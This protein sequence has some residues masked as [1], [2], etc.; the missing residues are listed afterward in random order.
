MDKT[1][2][3]SR[4]KA[5]LGNLLAPFVQLSSDEFPFLVPVPT[6]GDNVAATARKLSDV[7]AIIRSGR[8]LVYTDNMTAQPAK[9][10]N[11]AEAYAKGCMLPDELAMYE[12]WKACVIRLPPFDWAKNVLPVDRQAQVIFSQRA[13]AMDFI[14][15]HQGATPENAAYFMFFRLDLL[16]LVK[17]VTKLL[18]AKAHLENHDLLCRLSIAEIAE[19]KA[20]QLINGVVEENVALESEPRRDFVQ[21]IRESQGVLKERLY[22]LETK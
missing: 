16:P 22:L 14:W 9:A 8:S 1:S 11:D 20:L 6:A 15:H 7:A 18:S 17:A 2:P 4:N 21:S 12:D 19:I 3:F 5:N 13:A 10:T